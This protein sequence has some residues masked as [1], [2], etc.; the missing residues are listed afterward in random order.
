[1]R[2]SVLHP[3]VCALLSRPAE[4]P[5][6]CLDLTYA[7]TLLHYGYDLPESI[8]LHIMKRMQKKE[9]GW[10]LGA[11]LAQMAQRGW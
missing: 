11:M 9:I 4:N 7:H 5:Y 1:M 10:C 3:P 8:E 2:A 6:L